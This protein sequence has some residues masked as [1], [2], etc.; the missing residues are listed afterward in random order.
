MTPEEALAQRKKIQLKRR[1]IA[2]I[3]AL[4]ARFYLLK[5]PVRTSIRTGDIFT[6][7]ILDAHPRRALEIL[8]MP[9]STFL[10]LPHVCCV[11][12]Y[13][14][15]ALLGPEIDLYTGEG[16]LHGQNLQQR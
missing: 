5:T 6:R 7:E 8:R 11:S 2:I 9:T 1:K 16:S 13:S 12:S 10:E 3:L 4:Y 15:A 14:W